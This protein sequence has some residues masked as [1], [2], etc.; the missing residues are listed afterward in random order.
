VF[1]SA[2]P[3]G[4][5]APR[6]GPSSTPRPGTHRRGRALERPALPT[7]F[8]IFPPLPT[9]CCAANVARAQRQ[10]TWVPS[11]FPFLAAYFVGPIL[12]LASGAN[13]RAPK[14]FFMS[15]SRRSRLTTVKA[16]PSL[17]RP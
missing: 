17:L 16:G 13:Q 15:S 4:G 11:C 3:L 5:P 14:P 10:T 6:S 12:P 9:L 2:G 8:V 7:P 1:P